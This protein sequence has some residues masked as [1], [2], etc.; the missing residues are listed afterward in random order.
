MTVYNQV[1][2]PVPA[3]KVMKR[4]EHPGRPGNV[5]VNMKIRQ[6]DGDCRKMITCPLTRLFSGHYDSGVWILS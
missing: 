2:G 3:T 5:D 6:G 4:I 1:G